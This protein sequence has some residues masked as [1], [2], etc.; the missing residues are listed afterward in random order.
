VSYFNFNSRLKVWCERIDCEL[1]AARSQNPAKELSELGEALEIELH[2]LNLK[3]LFAA[4]GLRAVAKSMS[5]IQQ[6]LKRH[7]SA[8]ATDEGTSLFYARVISFAEDVAD[9][10]L[11][12]F[13]E[14]HKAYLNAQNN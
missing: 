4:M 5:A 3:R 7:K 1:E 10:E 13:Q 11:N 14:A 12:I 2:D 9:K 6:S 8:V